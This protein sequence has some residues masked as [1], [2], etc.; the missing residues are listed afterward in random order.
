M[1]PT[2]LLA[3]LLIAT[4]SAGCKLVKNPDPA[5]LAARQAAASQG[6]GAPSQP[7]GENSP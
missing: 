6:G 4:A 5:E 2:L 3:A 1:R 7:F